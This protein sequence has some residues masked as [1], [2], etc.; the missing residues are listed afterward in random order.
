MVQRLRDLPAQRVD[1]IVFR[2]RAIERSDVR[3]ELELEALLS[4]E[5]VLLSLQRVPELP[6][7][8]GEV[9]VETPTV[10]FEVPVSEAEVMS[11][12]ASICA[13]YV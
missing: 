13:E 7:Q 9:V 3:N 2:Q 11:D 1:S 6:G 5:F 4:S 12:V 10:H 8:T